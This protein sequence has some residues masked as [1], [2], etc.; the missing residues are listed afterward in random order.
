MG[1]TIQEGIGPHAM[2]GYAPAL[3]LLDQAHKPTEKQAHH[4][5]VLQP[6]DPGHVLKTLSN[7]KQRHSTEQLHLYLYDTPPE[8][9]ARHLLLLLV[10][11]DWEVP[12]RQ[13]TAVFLEIF[14]NAFLQVS[15]VQPVFLLNTVKLHTVQDVTCDEEVLYHPVDAHHSLDRPHVHHV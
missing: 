2:W 7:C 8:V 15:T 13:R 10:V 4:V 1:S 12:I 9:L 5:L 6:S 11:H 14:G 3:D